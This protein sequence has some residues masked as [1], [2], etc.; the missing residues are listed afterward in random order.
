MVSLGRPLAA[1][2]VPVGKYS[3]E[4]LGKLAKAEGYP[5]EYDKRVLANVVSQEE[6]V[7]SV[8]SK[9]ELGE[10]DAGF[11]YASDVTPA[12]ARYLIQVEI[13]DALNAIASYPI[14]VIAGAKSA[15]AARQFIELVRSDEGQRVLQQYG[16]L[17]AI[18]GEPAITRP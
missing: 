16:F 18:A 6:N 2:A 10:A 7:K 1:E 8:V 17:P 14:G 5:P 9:V 13:P 11:V 12:A 4:A 15:D 3:R